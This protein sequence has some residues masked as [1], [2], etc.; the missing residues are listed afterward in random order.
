MYCIVLYFYCI[1]LYCIFI[2]LYCIFIVLYCIYIV[3]CC[4]TIIIRTEMKTYKETEKNEVI[5]KSMK[6]EIIFLNYKY[7]KI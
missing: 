3:L 6:D 2:V 4:I 5:N 1:V 7:K